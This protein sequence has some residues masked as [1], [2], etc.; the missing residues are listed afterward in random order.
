[1]DNAVSL[2]FPFPIISY[3][4]YSIPERGCKR[5]KITIAQSALT[6]TRTHII[7]HFC[8]L[9]CCFANARPLRAKSRLASFVYVPTC[10]IY[11]DLYF[12]LWQNEPCIAIIVDRRVPTNSRL[13]PCAYCFNAF[14]DLFHAIYAI[15]CC[16]RTM[17]LRLFTRDRII[18]HG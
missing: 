15:V 18:C 17:Q 10:I 1:M 13:S 11:V 2:L 6:H 12:F 3:F 16:V 9:C 8:P 7:V 5:R 4:L 14:L